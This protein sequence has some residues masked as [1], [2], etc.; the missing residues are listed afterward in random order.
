MMAAGRGRFARTEFFVACIALRIL[1]GALTG[2]SG[3]AE[4][5]LV[6]FASVCRDGRASC[7]FPFGPV[8]SSSLT[9]AVEILPCA[10]EAGPCAAAGAR[11]GGAFAGAG[12]ADGVA[13]GLN[14]GADAKS[15]A[16]AEGDTAGGGGSA[17]TELG[18]TS[19]GWVVTGAPFA[20]LAS[21]F[22]AKSRPNAM[23]T[24]GEATSF[25]Y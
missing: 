8:V 24:P 16:V 18:T 14:A 20:W 11:S 22:P 9:E 19:A 1:D 7:G 21:A 6:G 13:T 2:A 23:S 15:G 25:A 10:P 17:G 3:S 12:P 5:R 4:A